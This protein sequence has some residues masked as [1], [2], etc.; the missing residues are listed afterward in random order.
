MGINNAQYVH[1]TC[2]SA[3]SFRMEG[4]SCNT[5]RIRIQS[6]RSCHALCPNQHTP[7]LRL[8]VCVFVCV[9][10]GE[11]GPGAC[12]CTPSS[13]SVASNEDVNIMQVNRASSQGDGARTSEQTRRAPFAIARARICLMMML[14][15]LWRRRIAS[16]AIAC[17]RSPKLGSVHRS[18][19]TLHV[20]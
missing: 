17:A 5:V 7:L 11:E 3:C 2:S 19:N 12:V 10:S 20:G 14:L 9:P 15:L 18:A 1:M 13:H 8:S 16:G 6:T 4:A